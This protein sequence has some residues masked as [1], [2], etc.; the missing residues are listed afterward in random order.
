MKGTTLDTN[1]PLHAGQ[2]MI[3]LTCVCVTHRPE[4]IL[5]MTHNMLLYLF[6]IIMLRVLS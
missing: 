6:I 1:L 2:T 3:R 4:H 5:E